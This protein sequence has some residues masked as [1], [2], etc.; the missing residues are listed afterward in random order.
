MEV[1]WYVY[2]VEVFS[3]YFLIFI[4]NITLNVPVGSAMLKR[5]HQENIIHIFLR[6]IPSSIWKILMV[7]YIY[8]FF[9]NNNLDCCEFKF[10]SKCK[11][12]NTNSMEP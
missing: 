1:K 10:L 2:L 11:F 5:D 9:I 4:E 6:F 7:I 3:G 8:Y 12:T